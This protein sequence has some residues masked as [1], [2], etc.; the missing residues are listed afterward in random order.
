[1]AR[2]GSQLDQGN[3]QGAI[4]ILQAYE[5]RK[6]GNPQV[7]EQ[8]AFAWSQKGDL[9]MAARYFSRLAELRPDQPDALLF[10]AQSLQ[11][12][13]DAEGAMVTY[14]QYLAKKPDDVGACLTFAAIAASNGRTDAAIGQYT[15]VYGIKPSADTAL[16]LGTLYLRKAD[17]QQAALWFER[18]KADKPQEYS[19]GMLEVAMRSQN[20]PKAENL[21]AHIKNTYPGVLE[22]SALKDAPATIDRWHEKIAE[23]KKAAAATAAV[24]PERIEVAKTA[25]AAVPATPVTPS[26][27][28]AGKTELSLEHL[29]KMDAVALEEV[30]EQHDESL[31]VTQAQAAEVATPQAAAPASLPDN[32]ADIVAQ[33]A[34]TTQPVPIVITPA[35]PQPVAGLP[36]QVVAAPTPEP[37]LGVTRSAPPP[38]AKAVPTNIPPAVAHPAPPSM[39][40]TLEEARKTAMAGKLEEA[41]RLY[42]TVL[43]KRPSAVVWNEFSVLSMSMGRPG[44][45]MAASLE[46]TRID[47]YNLD[48]A[49]QYLSVVE[50]VYD[51]RR[52]M[53]ELVVMRKRFPESPVIALALA[54]AYWQVD[55]NAA[56]A[57]YYYDQYL[58]RAPKN[59]SAYAEIL[60]ERDNVPM[61]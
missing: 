16:A 2:A 46:A 43:A 51:Q 15:Y 39:A 23:E 10:A 13:G 61:P 36:P 50:K 8:L 1:V 29:S 42:Q 14:Q 25:E 20:Y 57:R 52:V 7:V 3:T 56:T 59:T 31:V 60:A 33:P 9:R 27:P 11:Q 45:A 48:Y 28:D 38:P 55:G 19:L 6:P 4:D 30:R 17:M 41:A 54:R 40:D 53:S 21:I 37:P 49:V 34:E 18:A 32:V 47:P 26:L 44:Q 58:E 22:A 24:K 35:Q 5:E 12:A